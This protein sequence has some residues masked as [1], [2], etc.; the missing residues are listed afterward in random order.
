MKI[1]AHRTRNHSSEYTLV[2]GA[3][4]CESHVAGLA[5]F[6]SIAWRSP[7]YGVCSLAQTV[8][9]WPPA[10]STSGSKE[11][12]NDERRKTPPTGRARLAG[13]EPAAAAAGHATRATTTSSTAVGPPQ[14]DSRVGV[15]RSSYVRPV[16]SAA[17]FTA[18]V[19]VTE[20]GK[21]EFFVDLLVPVLQLHLLPLCTVQ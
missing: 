2:M 13:S 5:L 8:S 14:C 10:S 7:A 21:Y 15:H 4:A 11:G 19:W 1:I 20:N 6:R 12:R 17:E 3:D 18:A 16:G 9:G